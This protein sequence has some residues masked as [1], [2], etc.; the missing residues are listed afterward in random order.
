LIHN[1]KLF[2][3]F[4]FWLYRT[5]F[6]RPL[7]EDLCRHWEH[8]KIFDKGVA[9]PSDPDSL[10]RPMLWLSH[11]GVTAQTHYD[12]NHNFLIQ[13]QGHKRVLLFGPQNELYSYPNIHRSFR[14]SQLPLERAPTERTR[15]LYPLRQPGSPL[16]ATAEEVYL[17]PSDVLYIPPYWQHRIESVT[18]ALSLSVISPAAIEAALA[19]AFWQP[20]P[21]GECK[22][23]PHKRKLCVHYFLSL[24]V[25]EVLPLEESLAMFAKGLYYTRYSPL[26]LLT[27][28]S[29]ASAICEGYTEDEDGKALLRQ[30]TKKFAKSV[31]AIWGILSEIPNPPKNV[32]TLFLR[33]YAEQVI[34]WAVGPDQVAEF[35]FHCLAEMSL[36][37]L[38]MTTAK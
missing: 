15:R 14:Q 27:G 22:A 4:K 34:R 20:V 37:D 2:N 30:H 10:W 7:E 28:P 23:T 33:D 1:K 24:L 16:P 35:L 21:F 25:A 29:N 11:P 26:Y 32:F 12:T 19:E 8:F 36:P 13:I 18:L 5:F 31:N 17:G 9:E 6:F 3:H 38:S